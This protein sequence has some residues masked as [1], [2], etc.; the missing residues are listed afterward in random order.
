MVA[1]G[2][3]SCATA[4]KL[5]DGQ[6]ARQGSEDFQRSKKYVLAY[7]RQQFQE[8]RSKNP[9]TPDGQIIRMVLDD[10][11]ATMG[12]PGNFKSSEL[13][14]ANQVFPTPKESELN[15]LN[16]VLE[17]SENQRDAGNDD[18]IDT[19]VIPGTGREYEGMVK[20][21]EAGKPEIP[22]IYHQLD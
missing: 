4:L 18:F 3:I 19:E 21:I 7:A 14:Y 8:Q 11:K 12:D 13:Y 15:T 10:V 2:N 16:N 22:L 5:T 20:S 6:F 9:G 17:Y 1:S